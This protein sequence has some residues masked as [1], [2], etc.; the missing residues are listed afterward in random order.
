MLG[1]KG[2]KVIRLGKTPNFLL[3]SKN[4]SL[5]STLS[6]H[7]AEGLGAFHRIQ[8]HELASARLC[9]ELQVGTDVR[10]FMTCLVRIALKPESSWL[11]AKH[12][13][14][15]SRSEYPEPWHLTERARALSAATE[16]FA[17][18]RSESS[19][20]TRSLTQQMASIRLQGTRVVLET[21]QPRSCHWQ[22]PEHFRQAELLLGSQRLGPH[23]SALRGSRAERSRA[24]KGLPDASS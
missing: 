4:R 1:R 3:G 20:S 12:V 17:A 6:L 8:K 21:H 24:F 13:N 7:V 18:C 5:S 11:R 14:E 9:P 19:A 15:K 23:S 2:E 16:D 10:G 22:C